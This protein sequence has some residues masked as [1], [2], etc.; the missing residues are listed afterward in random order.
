[1]FNADQAQHILEI[2]EL[3]AVGMYTQSEM[4]RKLEAVCREADP[5]AKFED[6][7]VFEAGG[8]KAVLA[9]AEEVMNSTSTMATRR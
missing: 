9:Q 6:D 5:T 2:V 1:M 3:T 7:S 4:V 8:D